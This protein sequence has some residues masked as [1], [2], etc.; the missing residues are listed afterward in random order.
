MTTVNVLNR[1]TGKRTRVK[2]DVDFTGNVA[3]M[4]RNISKALEFP[5]EELDLLYAGQSLKDDKSLDSYRIHPGITVHVMKK[6][7]PPKITAEVADTES[8]RRAINTLQASLA[9]PVFRNMVEQMLAKPETLDNLIENTPGLDEDPIAMAIL[10]T[11][12]FLTMWAE[13]D[14][15]QRLIDSHPTLGQ[16]A[17]IVLT[18]VNNGPDTPGGAGGSSRAM[19]SLDRMSDEDE[20]RPQRQG[21]SGGPPSQI[22]TSQLAAALMATGPSVPQNTQN[23][24]QG[25]AAQE[26]ITTDFFRQAIMQEQLQQMRDMGITDEAQAQRA[27]QAT[28][29]NIEAAIEL[30]F[31]NPP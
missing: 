31:G 16:A 11:P 6:I 21:A 5:Q 10:Q 2:V 27:L 3:A 23:R 13:S 7:K 9:S 25:N 15:V 12:E 20:V 26:P 14:K 24:P 19:Y 18:S 17:V 22:T 30:I 29:G 4:K 1:T 8:V 28:G